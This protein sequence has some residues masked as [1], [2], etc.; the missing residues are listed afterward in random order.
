MCGRYTLTVDPEEIFDAFDWLERPEEAFF[1]AEPEWCRPRYNV[2][3]SQPVPVIGQRAKEGELR[4]PALAWFRWGLL[5]FW[6]ESAKARK[7]INA[8]IETV[9][10]RNTFRGPFERRRCLV[11]ADGWFEWRRGEGGAKVP[12]LVR[13]ADRGLFTLAGIWDRWKGEE[14]VR[15]GF[16]ILTRDAVG[17]LEALHP[18]MPVVVPPELRARWLDPTV[19][20]AADDPRPAL[21][22]AGLPEGFEIVRVSTHVNDVRHD[23]PSAIEEVASEEVT[24]EEAGD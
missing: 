18:R 15:F 1:E 20:P 12:H 19:D 8:R 11:P 22:A 21:L 17:P 4:P 14:E 5:P 3:P 24:I 2:A 13:R 16:A 7:P 23:D 9:H 6:A 10:T